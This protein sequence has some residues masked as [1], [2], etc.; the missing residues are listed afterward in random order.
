MFNLQMSDTIR[1]I[2]ENLFTSK[3]LQNPSTNGTEKINPKSLSNMFNNA[4]AFLRYDHHQKDLLNKT[5]SICFWDMGRGRWKSWNKLWTEKDSNENPIRMREGLKN[6]VPM[7]EWWK[8]VRHSI[9]SFFLLSD[10]SPTPFAYKFQTTKSMDFTTT[11]SIFPRL[12][13]PS[14]FSTWRKFH[15][16]EIRINNSSLDQKFRRETETSS[17]VLKFD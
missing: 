2:F 9:Y 17:V 12:H 7:R 13:F 16:A 8:N 15:Y 6:G 4:A 1:W 5:L 10:S 14:L 11:A 3:R